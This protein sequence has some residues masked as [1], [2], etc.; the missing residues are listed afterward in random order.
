MRYLFKGMVEKEE[1][2]LLLSLTNIKS[3]S[4]INALHAHFVDGIPTVRAAARFD[5]PLQN[6]HRAMARL[7]EVAQTVEKIKEIN[8]KYHQLSDD[9]KGL[10]N[11]IKII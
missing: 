5:V 8:F 6:L 2:N 7:N 11:G 9:K 3:E 10:E 4:M 1:L